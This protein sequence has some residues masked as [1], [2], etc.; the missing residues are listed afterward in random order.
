MEPLE[1][2]TKKLELADKLERARKEVEF[3]NKRREIIFLHEFEVARNCQKATTEFGLATCRHLFLLNGGALIALLSFMAAI[4]A[5]Q[6]S[7]IDFPAPF[8]LVGRS[9]LAFALG[10]VFAVLVNFAGHRNYVRATAHWDAFAFRTLFPDYK[11]ESDEITKTE[12]SLSRTYL[13]SNIL[14]AL[15]LVSFLVG[16]AVFSRSMRII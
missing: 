12:R 9:L 16:V 10:L 7:G 3:L 6:N 2:E 4:A 13:A 11:S 5:R 15:S 8:Q 1:V 14:S